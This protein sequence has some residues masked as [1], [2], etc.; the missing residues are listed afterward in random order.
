MEEL[1]RFLALSRLPGFGPIKFDKLLSNFSTLEEVWQASLPELMA[2]GLT[3]IEAQ[4]I[5]A[6]KFIGDPEQELLEM[7]H[8]GI[9]AITIKDD[10]YPPLLK[11]I[12]GA[13]PILYYRGNIN[14]L[15]KSNLAVVGS[16]KHTAYGQMA[17]EKIVPPIAQCGITIVSGLALGI[18]ALA[19][20]TTLTA[21]GITVAVLGSDLSWT[22]IGPKNNFQLAQKIIDGGGCLL[23]DYPLGT[24]ANK[25]T[26]P[27]RNRIISGL[28]QGVLLIEASD[29]SGSLITAGYALEQNRDV[30]AIPG[31]IFSPYSE[32]TNN[33]IRKGAKLTASAEDIIGE[34]AC[35]MSINLDKKSQLADLPAEEKIII[36]NL[37]SEPLHL[38][39]LAEIINI[40]INVL[41]SKLMIME[42][43]GLVRNIGNG[44]YVKM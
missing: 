41:N 28:S 44:K 36:E 29:H 2:C 3:E 12:Y 32:G 9:S 42:L 38:D 27:Q 1:K 10:N 20:Q 39:K 25:T 30:F 18:D 26:F 17:V 14:C 24:Q 4:Q 21:G 40:R 37:S 43:N 11:E 8:A 6:K 31:N 5:I 16:R 19:H 33:L 15:K 13:P 7:E 34:F 35:Q 22:N 23:S